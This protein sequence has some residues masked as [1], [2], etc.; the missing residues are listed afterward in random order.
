MDM[1]ITARNLWN[2]AGMGLLLKWLVIRIVSAKYMQI[3]FG[4]FFLRQ[5]PKQ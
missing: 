3:F 1:T 4:S 2:R 5:H